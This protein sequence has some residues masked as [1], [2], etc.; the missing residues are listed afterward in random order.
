MEGWMHR[1][2]RY[3]LAA[4]V[5]VIS[6][7]SDNQ[8]SPDRASA[9]AIAPVRPTGPSSLISPPL[10]CPSVGTSQTTV[11]TLLP[12]LFGP[13]GGR[14]GK[15]QGYSNNIEQGRR[16]GNTL[17]ERTYVD[18][19]VNFTLQTYYAGNLIGG[20]SEA[21]KNRVLSFFYALYCASGISPIPDLS[22]IFLAQNTVLI[23]NGTPTTVV[24]DPLDSAAV[25]VEQGEVPSTIFGTF[26]SVYKT[27]NPLPTSLDWYGIAGYKQG[28]F[29]FVANPAV[30]FTSPVLTGVCVAFDASIVSKDD[31]RLA[32]AVPDTYTVTIPGNSKLT[33]SGGTIE[34]GAPASTL[35]LG[36][37]CPPIEVASRSVFGRVLQQFARLFLPDNLLAAGTTTKGGTGTQVVK[38]SPFAAVDIKLNS[39]S[40]GPSSTQYIGVGNTKDTVPV[41]LTVKTRNGLTPING[42]PVTFAPGP[43]GS[44]SPS[45]V[46]TGTDGTAA[47]DWTIVAGTD[48]GTGTPLKAPL[49]FNPAAVNFSVDAVQLTE[50]SINTPTSPL[51]PDGVKDVAY[52]ATFTASGGTGSGYTWTKTSGA[53]P[54]GL[55]LSGAGV[56]S[57]IPSV[58]GT[59]NFTVQVTSG[60]ATTT[61]AYTLTI[62]P[63]VSI[64]APASLADGAQG[65]A[66]PSTLFSASGGTGSGYTY[67][68]TGGALPAG[69]GLTGAGDLSGTPTA[70]GTF[71]FTVQVTSGAAT[72]A[73][74]YSLTILPPVSNIAP[75]SLAAGA[76]GAAYPSTI[77]SASGGNGT[78]YTYAVTGGALPAGLGLTGAGVLSGTPTTS[79]TF[80]F[81]VQVT[82]GPATGTTAYTLTILPPVAISPSTLPSAS[83]GV[84]YS[85]TLQ[86]TGGTGTYSWAVTGGSLPA[87]STATLPALGGVPTAPGTSTFTV[88]ASSVGGPGSA[89]QQYSIAVTYPTFAPLAFQPG[90]SGSQCYALNAILAPNIA[91]RV[92]D[93]S[94]HPVSG[95]QVD[96]V[97]VTNN[98]SK[99][100]PSQPFATSGANG[101]A[102]FNTLSINKNGGYR[103]IASTKSP[104]PVLSVQSGKFTISPSC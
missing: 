14:R 3:L 19:L 60:P 75:A 87:W 98:G 63:P 84:A 66:Y 65:A 49:S 22:G 62:L 70:S 100:V 38:F 56:L 4:A 73:K 50:L 76:Q 10:S 85:Q 74:A 101:L 59:V 40:T 21:T 71:N 61:K 42:I 18:S 17:L 81:T 33:T 39:T 47:S 27:T 93:Q 1:R 54:T 12:Q 72:G 57:G 11:D 77:F 2:F 24:S 94:G 80:N 7:C 64:T 45:S 97:A 67:A 69:L 78:S 9:P 46:T 96:I 31:L 43:I 28:A 102:V 20:Q 48:T 90:P 35:P 8:L 79:G 86:A 82:S 92:T 99:V 91:V 103:L 26:V 13:G 83:V 51:S 68:V 53:L 95:V 89:S 88:Q 34:I 15:A 52:S 5:V 55:T 104:W 41:S 29:E 37:A 58:S 16:N 23:R 30:T 6:A 36:L 44:F 25:E 32:H